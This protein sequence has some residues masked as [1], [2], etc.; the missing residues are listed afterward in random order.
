MGQLSLLQSRALAPYPYPYL[1]MV[2]KSSLRSS[3]AG[4]DQISLL[5]EGC[6]ELPQDLNSTERAN[7]PCLPKVA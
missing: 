2:V 7:Y 1:P 5:T 6:E 4:I 3:R